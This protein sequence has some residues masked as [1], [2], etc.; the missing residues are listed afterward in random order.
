M[1]KRFSRQAGGAGLLILVIVGKYV[2]KG[3]KFRSADGKTVKIVQPPV[4]GQP[5]FAR[6]VE[7]LTQAPRRTGNEVSILRNGRE[8]FPALLDAIN[9]A[10][11]S[12][13]FSSYIW[14][15]GKAADDIAEALARQA[16]KGVSVRVLLDAFGSAKL[17]REV[18][19]MLEDAGVEVVW[20]RPIRWY[21]LGKANNR[22]HRRIL[23]IDGVMAFAGGV[24]IAEAW[25]GN[26]E[27][28]DRWRETHVRIVGPAVRDL[29]GGFLENWA[30]A[31]GQIPGPELLPDIQPLDG[32]VPVLVLRSSPSGGSTITET[33]FLAAIVGATKRLWITTAYFAPRKGFVDALCAAAQRGVDV[34][35]LAN[36]RPIDKEVVRKAGQ[37]SYSRLLAAGV[38]MFEYQ[39]ALLHAKVILVDDGWA[40][41]GSA[42][43]DNR[44]FALEEEINVSIESPA[45][46]EQLAGH[47]LDDLTAS[48]QIHLEAW[49]HRPL[50]NRAY[51]VASEVVR[52]SL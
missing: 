50:R 8:I 15:A 39:K 21:Q 46:V 18:V 3:I 51:E 6:L 30:E 52:Q 10:R 27:Y 19:H 45:I 37:H 41:V 48:D 42:N 9:S 11:K 31:T 36:G 40:N 26:V 4:P 47:F 38:Q 20:F 44:S 22:M 7:S 33:L 34:R 24:G 13:L 16:R 35:I 14:W 29:V 25:E 49:K 5:E 28:V 23:A 43:F 2:F 12:I 1:S 17:D 32:G